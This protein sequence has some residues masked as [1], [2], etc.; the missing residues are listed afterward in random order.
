MKHDILLPSILDLPLPPLE[1]QFFKSRTEEA[2]ELFFPKI[3]PPPIPPIISKGFWSPH[4][5]ELLVKAISKSSP[6]LWDQV[7]QN[8]PGRSA[9]QCKERWLYRLNP[10]VKKTRFEKWEDDLIIAERTRIGNRWTLIAKKLPG[11][12]SCAVKNRWYSVLKNRA[13]SEAKNNLCI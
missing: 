3:E 7:A 6:I 9:L 13:F 12:T 2:G 5:D 4:E 8:V 11:R 10:E 1:S